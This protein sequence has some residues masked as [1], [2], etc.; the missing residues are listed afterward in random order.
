MFS[1]ISSP[2]RR[3]ARY[4]FSAA[5]F[6]VLG[7]LIVLPL[8]MVVYT[9]VIDVVPFSGDRPAAFTLANF[10]DVWSEEFF[11]ALGNTVIVSAGG[12]V[13]AMFFGC[14]LAWLAARSDVPWKP[15]VHLSGVMPLF[16]SLLVAAVTWSLLGA[17]FSGYLNIIFRSLG[18]PLG[19]EMRSLA[20]IAAVEGFYYAP[21]AYIFLHGALSLVHPDL[22]EAA[23]VHGASMTRTLRMVSFPL[24]KPAL[25][26]STLLI[27]VLIAEDFPVPQILGG[28]VGIETLSMRIYNLMTRV[29]SHPNQASALSVVLTVAVWVL[30]YTQRRIL[31][32][33]D[34]RTV[35]GK[36]M[37]PRIVSLGRW[38]WPAA[39]FAALYAFVAIG[40]P[41]WALLQ[42]A[43]RANLFIPNAA[44]FLDFS[45]FSLQNI[46]AAAT[47]IA[48]RD[49]LYNSVV[50]GLLTAAFG[51]VFFF[52]LAYVV[53]RT[54]LPGRRWLEYIAMVPLALPAIVL[55]LGILW[56]WVPVPLPIYG[57]IAILVIAFLAR[58]TPQGFRA[59]SSTVGQIH[60]DLEHAAQVAGA[61][62]WQTIRLVTLPLVR[63]GVA[64]AAFLLF[65]L[66]LRE[67]SA[68]LF[69]YT[70]RTRVISIVLLE[71]YDN[72]MWSNV[73]SISLLY[74]VLLIA[75]TLAGRRWMRPGI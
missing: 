68:S 65:V 36:G 11:I 61:T 38:R 44:A 15:L 48:V 41:I 73:A 1:D 33:R 6:G 75:V 64:A 25:I 14:G 22:E 71:S 29:P 23:A 55:A 63:G 31:G 13:V 5:L 20:G 67:V 19:I 70:T 24:V 8:V 56:T 9:S 57:S 51:S 3:S 17:G 69:L 74:T 46:V 21:Y 7:I 18:L 26:G 43:L 72:G 62:R 59:I 10:R 52:L 66:S 49:G 34:Y 50:A 30:I 39:G 35:T 37:Q 47:S 2:L 12:T 53:N 40:L 45:Q 42:G 32:T 27:F 4:G 16:V 60:D 54:D 28:P 58:F